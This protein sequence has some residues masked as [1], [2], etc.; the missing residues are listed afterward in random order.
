M[1]Y[2]YFRPSLRQPS[3]SWPKDER[4]LDGGKLCAA[5]CTSAQKPQHPTPYQ[6]AAYA[7]F[8]IPP[9]SYS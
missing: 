6:G 2:I 7:G 9:R 8:Q 1:V 4:A 5:S 3:V